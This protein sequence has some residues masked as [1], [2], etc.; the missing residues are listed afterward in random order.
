MSPCIAV[1]LTTDL[2]NHNAPHHGQSKPNDRHSI[3]LLW[4]QTKMAFK[5]Q[6]GLTNIFQLNLS[7]ASTELLVNLPTH[8]HNSYACDFCLADEAF[9]TG[10]LE[11]TSHSRKK[12][13][14]H[15]QAYTA[16]MGV[17]PYL[18][19]TQFSKQIRLLSGFAAQVRTGF[20]GQGNQVKNCTVSTA[21]TAIGRQ[22]RWPAT[23]I[24]PKYQ[25]LNAF[26]H[27]FK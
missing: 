10:R 11:A 23:Q 20:Y 27:T 14:D 22:S 1:Q 26:C 15:W 25:D 24:L 2:S 16:P 4:K 21:L 8:L 17:D 12:Y 19:G 7:S 3:T 5:N 13:W 6:R 9:H 18:Q